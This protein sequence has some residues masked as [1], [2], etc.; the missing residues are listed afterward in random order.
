M[1][2]PDQPAAQTIQRGEGRA[3]IL[4]AALELF[5]QRG[6][7]DVSMQQIADAAGV[8]KATLYHHFA[9]KEDLFATLVR[10]V[11]NQFWQETITRAQSEGPLEET[12]RDIVE[13]VATAAEETDFATWSDDM[14]RHISGD[15]LQGIL[16]EHPEPHDAIRDLFRRAIERGEMRPLDVDGLTAIFI[17]ILMGGMNNQEH[18][19]EEQWTPDPA[20]IVDI[21]LNGVRPE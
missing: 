7:A 4:E 13:Y 12:L 16:T 5:G 3:R 14:H 11:I 10:D 2:S 15:V 17:G 21:F 19:A 20:L 8:K 1:S 6:F 9:G 18:S